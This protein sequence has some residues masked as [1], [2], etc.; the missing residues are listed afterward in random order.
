MNQELIEK[1]IGLHQKHSNDKD[2]CRLLNKRNEL[3]SKDMTDGEYIGEFEVKCDKY[4]IT[5]VNKSFADLKTGH[6]KK[7]PK[8]FIV[9]NMKIGK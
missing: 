9:N 8:Y 3:K 5:D 4:I 2:N 1:Y 6:S 7:N